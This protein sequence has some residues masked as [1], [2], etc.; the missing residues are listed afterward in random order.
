MM[1]AGE[2]F[3]T[4]LND[5]PV[6]L[7]GQTLVGMVGDG[8]G[9]LQNGVRDDHL[10]R[11]QVPANAEV[12]ERALRLCAPE[13]VGRNIDFAETIGF[14]ANVSHFASSVFSLTPRTAPPQFGFY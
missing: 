9:F 7:V 1:L 4:D 2:D 10:A 5:Q 12:L 6:G 8:C 11:H 3:V 14:L 13:P